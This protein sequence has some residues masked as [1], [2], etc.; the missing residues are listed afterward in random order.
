MYYIAFFY[1]IFEYN[2]IHLRILRLNN[3]KKLELLAPA[4]NSEIGIAAINFGTDAVY[5]GPP[6]FGAR[7]SAGNTIKEIELLINYAHKFNAKVYATVNT[8]LNDEELRFAEKQIYELYHI[9]IDAIIVQD[10]GLTAVSLPPVPLFA[11]TQTDNYNLEKIKFLENSGFERII[12]ARELSLQ[13]IKEIRKNT[14]VNLESF[15][16]G[17]LCV[18]FSG[19]CYLSMSNCGRSANRGECSQPCRLPYTLKN[20]SDDVVGYEGYYLSLKDLNLSEYIYNLIEAGINS[21]KIEGRLKDINYVKN[22]V[23]F[24]RKKID[25]IITNSDT[26]SKSSSG[27]INFDFEPDLDRTFNR[28]KTDYF[29]NERH[30]NMININSPK[31]I[32]VKVANVIKSH[33]NNL[34]IEKICDIHTGDG[35]CYFDKS[36]ELCGFYINRIENDCIFPSAKVEIPNGGELF[37]NQDHI[38]ENMLKTSKTERKINIDLSITA[39]ET[40]FILNVIDEDNNQL[41]IKKIS[42]LSVA[43]NAESQKNNIITSLSK[44]GNTIFEVKAV[45]I[46]SEN[47]YFIPKSLLNEARRQITE[48]L[49]KFR[50]DNYQLQKRSKKFEVIDYPYIEQEDTYSLNIMNKKADEFYRIRNVDKPEPAPESNFNYKNIAL[51][52]TKYCIKF[53]LGACPNFQ[54]DEENSNNEVK[55]AKELFLCSADKKY[56]LE[57]D[58]KKCE[59]KVLKI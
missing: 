43:E 27:H 21:F 9:G 6:K 57:F 58:C 33:F 8:I 25:N 48:E 56:R 52:T 23:A 7:S 5:I 26:L 2:F 41:N 51:M 16:Y 46:L 54:K 38:F 50:S 14:S 59:M 19:K 53:E 35:L 4:K 17:A 34:E 37:R 40:G 18:S 20:E 45:N 10:M 11:S 31:S 1:F 3:L 12:L 30:R 39:Y 29:I 13:Q 44:T 15:V 55:V 32:G 49:E 36:G 47:I 42:N 24:F 28:G 22:T